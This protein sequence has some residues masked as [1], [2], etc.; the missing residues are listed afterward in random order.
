MFTGA[1]EFSDWP[2]EPIELVDG[3]HYPR[4]PCG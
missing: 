4:H 1:S 3:I 2:V